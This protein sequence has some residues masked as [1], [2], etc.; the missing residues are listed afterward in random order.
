[1]SSILLVD[2]AAALGELFARALTESGGH[3]VHFVA[4]VSEVGSALAHGPFDLAIVDL[5]FPQENA[6]GIDALAE[7]HRLHPTTV[8]AIS[9]QGDRWVADILRDAVELL[10]IST[11]LSKS[12]PLDFQLGMIES[13]LRGVVPPF[14]PA[15]RVMLGAERHPLRTPDRF[16]ELFPHQGHQK[17]WQVLVAAGH[18]VTYQDVVDK[19]GLKLNTIKNYRAQLLPELHVHG[20]HD[21]SLR[22][23]QQF[24]WRCRAF[25]EPFLTRHPSDS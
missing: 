10:P 12:A 11:V 15:I 6:T 1:L 22:D 21:P 16:V 9:T 4:A 18:E 14:D 23:M 7:I 3:E 17:L 25:L 13:L 5:S 20:L 24:A 19:T 2:D 8:L